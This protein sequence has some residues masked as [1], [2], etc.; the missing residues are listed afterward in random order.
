[1][2]AS[3]GLATPPWGVP[4]VLLYVALLAAPRG[5]VV[6]EGSIQARVPWVILWIA[7]GLALTG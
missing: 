1:M 3:S 2:L 6:L 4:R 5:Y 7:V